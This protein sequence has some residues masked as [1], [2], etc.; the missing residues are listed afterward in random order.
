[1]NV[2]VTGASGVIGR[3]VIPTLLARGHRVTAAG[4]PS[5]RLDALRNTGASVSALDIFDSAA[6][7]RAMTGHDVVINLA[8]AVPSNNR[9]FIPGAWRGTDRIRR[10]A[11]RALTDAAIRAGVKTFVQ[12]SFAPIY[13][14]GG[15]TWITESAR[16]KPARYNE[17]AMDAEAS[18]QRFGQ[19]GT[20]I[21][22]RF[23]LFY[24]P[25]DAFSDTVL[26]TVKRGWMPVL[27][28]RESYV[29]MV[30]HDDAAGAVVSA[31]AVPAGIYNVVDDEPMTREALGTSLASMMDVSPPKFLP[32][33]LAKLGGSLG[34]TITRS[35]R[36]SNSALKV[37]SGWSP[38]YPSM[39]EGF[40]AVLENAAADPAAA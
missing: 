31:I 12:E 16:V 11:S 37:A 6:A 24:G 33:W 15:D 1:M 7:Q 26:S 5:A 4:R 10:D 19:S 21:V 35:L 9:M 34:E 2:F 20:A 36:I 18:A 40:G 27:G 14:D 39:R 13:A 8:T 28:K 30:T 17:S 3:R 23:A 32:L 38:R 25:G 29:S 22:L